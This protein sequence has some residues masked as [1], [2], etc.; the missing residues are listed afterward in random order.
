[1]ANCHQLTHDRV[2]VE[3]SKNNKVEEE[4]LTFTQNGMNWLCKFD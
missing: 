3:E 1:M 4:T 2:Q